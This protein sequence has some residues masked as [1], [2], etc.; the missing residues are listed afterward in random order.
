MKK[1]AID[2]DPESLDSCV[3]K[4]HTLNNLGRYEEALESYKKAVDLDHKSVNAW[5][6]RG[7][8]LN[9]LERYEEALE[10]YQKGI[11][12]DPKSVD[13]WVNQG[14]ALLDLERYEKALT[15][16]DRA[17]EIDSKNH[18]ALALSILKNFEKAITAID[19]AINLEP[20]EVLYRA[21]RGIILA[22]AGRY[23]EALAECEQAIKQDR[24]HESGYYG[25]ACYYALQGEIGQAIDNLQKAIDIAPRFSR[26]EAKHNP[27]FDSIRDDEKFRDL[28][29][30]ESKC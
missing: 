17:V 29:Q 3:N 6:N 2:L 24:K 8:T 5:V 1:R 16:C 27:D 9:N 7:N 14:N 21:N 22:R 23:T 18:Q 26:S 12:L 15:A 30:S 25:K 13:A 28:M 19:E 20:Q 10:S 11:D 4:G